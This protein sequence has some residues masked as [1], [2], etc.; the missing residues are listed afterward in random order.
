[1]ILVLSNKYVLSQIDTTQIWLDSTHSIDYF[2]K[3]EISFLQNKNLSTIISNNSRFKNDPLTYY[4]GV[5]GTDFRRI[6][7]YLEATKQ[8]SFSLMYQINGFDRL[9]TNIRP[10]LGFM[11][12]TDLFICNNYYE[13]PV[14]LVALDCKLYES[15]EKQSDGMFSGL[16]TIV[17]SITNDTVKWIHSDSGD[18]SEYNGVFVGNWRKYNS[19]ILKS[20]IFSFEPIGLYNELP[21][22]KDFYQV[23]DD[24]PDENVVPKD[25]Y[26]KNGWENYNND[27]K[28]KWW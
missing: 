6:D 12:V 22:C 10:L 20:T 17:F 14:Y 16:Y 15:G 21:M 5:F 28:T 4:S 3:T 26:I 27:N 11:K 7:F 18:F 8:D 19:N 25:K 9:G 1:M 13:N 2:E 24:C 23:C